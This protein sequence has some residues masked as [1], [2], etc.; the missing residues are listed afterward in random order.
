VAEIPRAIAELEADPPA[1]R[2][3]LELPLARAAGS[4]AV[5]AASL[6]TAK[7]L[8]CAAVSGSDDIQD[9]LRA[10]NEEHERTRQLLADGGM[11]ATPGGAPQA[12]L[13]ATDGAA[14]GELE[15]KLVWVFGSP[16]S[17]SS[18]MLRLLGTQPEIAP[19]NESYL[20]AHLV[21]VG[22]EVE[23][24]EYYEH[25]ERAEDPSYFFAR[26]YMPVLRPMLHELVLRG[27][28]NQLRQ[29]GYDPIPSWVAIKEPNGSHAADT[30]ASLLPRS[31]MLFLLRDGRDVV[32]S[33]LDAMLGSDSWWAERTKG[34]GRP[35]QE[36]L[37]F[38]SQHS[39][40]WVRRTMATQRAYDSLPEDQR[41]L[42]RYEEILADTPGQ[43]LR[44]FEWLGL[45][46]GDSDV[47]EIAKRHAFEAA[48]R[49]R[50]GP[51]KPM[52]AATPG[53]WRENLTEDEQ[54]TMQEIMGAKLTE[55]G[56]DA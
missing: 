35:P 55:L 1:S 9:V 33:I 25:G 18:W 46:V 31:R 45:E 39:N 50:R 7:A 38:V 43:L 24:G 21:P 12:S 30:I 19:V 2:R 5:T 6:R 16:R 51:G 10:A 44:I 3:D 13:V 15:A 34:M 20:G 32:D 36:R 56:Y 53:L 14:L 48:P 11:A 23:A 4:A 8:P 49:D 17:G 28:D 42:V 26:D 27:F 54:R 22:G 40:L 41:L 47:R 52:R 37:A 29:M